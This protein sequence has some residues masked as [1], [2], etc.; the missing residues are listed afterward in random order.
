MTIIK[1]VYIYNNEPLMGKGAVD[2]IDTQFSDTVAR[3]KEIKAYYAGYGLPELTNATW[4]IDPVKE[5]EEDKPIR[6]VFNKQIGTKGNADLIGQVVAALNGLPA[7]EPKA[8]AMVNH[9]L[10][11]PEFDLDLVIAQNQA[12]IFAASEADSVANLIRQQGENLW[13]I[14]AIPATRPPLGF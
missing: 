3:I 9:L 7:F 12:V 11:Q 13:R 4:A 2:E 14:M 1:L 6:V 8:V 5:G 10:S